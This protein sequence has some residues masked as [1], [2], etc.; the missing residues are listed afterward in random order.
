MTE[1]QLLFD[2]RP[3][4]RTHNKQQQENEIL[5]GIFRGTNTCA[6]EEWQENIQKSGVRKSNAEVDLLRELDEAMGRTSQ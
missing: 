5:N 3:L 2:M 6:S 1:S 4:M